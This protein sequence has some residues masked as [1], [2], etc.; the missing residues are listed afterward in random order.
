LTRTPHL[1]AGQTTTTEEEQC[2]VNR[3]FAFHVNHAVV[4]EMV[5]PFLMALGDSRCTILIDDP[6][7]LAATEAE[8]MKTNH[9]QNLEIVDVSEALNLGRQWRVGVSVTQLGSL[10]KGLVSEL[11]L[12]TRRLWKLSTRWFW[13]QARRLWSLIRSSEFRYPRLEAK[14]TLGGSPLRPRYPIRHWKHMKR[15][16]RTSVKLEHGVYD[17]TG[18]NFGPANRLFDAVMCHGDYSQIR[19]RKRFGLRSICVDYPKYSNSRAS[20]IENGL[21]A[22]AGTRGKKPVVIWLPSLHEEN[23]VANFAGEVSSLAPELDVYVK[24]HPMSP[25]LQIAALRRAGVAEVPAHWP[26]N[27]PELFQIADCTL[28]DAGGTGFAAIY[29]GK[30]PLFLKIPDSI[31][32]ENGEKIPEKIAGEYFGE[33]CPGEVKSAVLAVL[34]DAGAGGSRSDSMASFRSRFFSGGGVRDLLAGAEFLERLA[35]ESRFRATV[36]NSA[37]VKRLRAVYWTH[38]SF[39]WTKEGL[40]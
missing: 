4:V 36:Q 14:K 25:E 22:K 18:Y 20:K 34:S 24:H 26:K 31:A 33:I 6:S 40:S 30:R 15:L 39:W 21:I 8:K 29:L 16:F 35:H 1:G 10:P 13:S 2:A 28:H 17:V 5:E 27:L 19:Y 37:I 38:R 3:P 12:L 32:V 23:S 11:D 7:G 9:M